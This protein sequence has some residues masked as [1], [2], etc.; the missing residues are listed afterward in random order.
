MLCFVQKYSESKR[1]KRKR[2]AHYDKLKE[3]FA[4]KS[5]IGGLAMG[6]VE[7]AAIGKAA[8]TAQEKVPCVSTARSAP[9]A[10]EGGDSSDEV[11]EVE[12]Q[13]AEKLT[14]HKRK[15]PMSSKTMWQ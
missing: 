8:S 4:G 15:S 9:D 5:G 3:I 6:P 13:T 2:L 7:V 14:A 10:E 11:R 1:F 12:K